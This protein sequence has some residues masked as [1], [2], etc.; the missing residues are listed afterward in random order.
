[1]TS[2][3]Q[4]K[5]KAR[6]PA[7]FGAVLLFLLILALTG[8][9][10]TYKFG[11]LTFL[12]DS[13]ALPRLN[14]IEATAGG[15]AS[16]ICE[17]VTQPLELMKVRLQV[18]TSSSQ[19]SALAVFLHAI[20]EDGIL[21]LWNGTSAAVLRQ[22]IY[23]WVKMLLYE[24]IR[25]L[26]ELQFFGGKVRNHVV[27]IMVVAGGVAGALG[28]A[29]SQWSDYMKVRMQ[30]DLN[31]EYKSLMHC[32]H[33]SIRKV[34]F[35]G[36]YRG[37]IPACQRS[38]IVNASELATYGYF[39]MLVVKYHMGGKDDIVT[40]FYASAMAGSSYWLSSTRLV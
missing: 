6:P 31:G 33:K 14:F 18:G 21:S 1:M 28:C 17:S 15:F 32:L 19:I 12:D 10:S 35:S 16:I 3:G 27:W 24:P 38:F 7:A 20:R 11:G 5:E 29:A 34:G 25:S 40:H 26:M 8:I 13:F 37:I 4:E 9:I 36:M 30:A 39:K 23:Q 22:F 2:V